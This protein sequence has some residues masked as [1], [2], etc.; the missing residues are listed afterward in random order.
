MQCNAV[1]AASL[2][3][4]PHCLGEGGFFV[5]VVYITDIHFLGRLYMDKYNE[6][7]EYKG[8]LMSASSTSYRSSQILPLKCQSVRR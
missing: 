8:H 4:F 2:L 5:F 1:T 3:L 7:L 6:F